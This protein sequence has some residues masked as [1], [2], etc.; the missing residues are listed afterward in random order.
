MRKVY[1]N[2][3]IIYL[4]LGFAGS[5]IFAM[6]S[7]I[8][9]VYQVEAAKLNPF[10]IVLVGAV[11]E[12]TTFFCEI[13]TGIIADMYSRRLSI[14]IGYCLLG[15]GF[16]VEGLLPYLST[17]L[18]AQVI[19]GIGFTFTSGAEE[20][21][22]AGEVGD[23]NIGPVYMRGSQ[24]A[25]FGAILGTLISV[26]LANFQLSL[27]IIV[28]GVAFLIL[29]LAL[30]IVMPEEKF[31]P[32]SQEE[33]NSWEILND[34][35]QRSWKHIRTSSILLI[36][37]S[38]TAFYGASSEGFTRLWTVEFLS[39]FTFPTLDHLKPVV[40]FGIFQIGTM[41]LSI[42]GTEIV[43][44]ILHV[45]NNEFV[46]RVQFILNVLMIL[47]V[48]VFGLAQNFVLALVAFWG[49]SMLLQISRPIYRAWLTSHTD[50]NVRAT[51]LSASSQV[52]SFGRILGGPIIG[53]VGALVSIRAAMVAVG[54]VLSP[55]LFFFIRAERRSKITSTEIAPS[56]NDK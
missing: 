23:E 56:M 4:L 16:L 36:I 15:L 14:V 2:A 52:N 6:L 9:I 10:Q 7:T 18:L 3:Y 8:E 5:L 29:S 43:K 20:A 46:A 41:I 39:G 25:Q 27:P 49:T 12:I 30:G 28:S 44:R 50:S 45:K 55:V 22:I 24:M 26:G 19:W 48:V 32:R 51:L 35:F 33:R 34:T 21:W 47:S 40:W 31:Q 11:L 13:P 17:I 37:I 42:V 54:V 38:I 1:F 53:A